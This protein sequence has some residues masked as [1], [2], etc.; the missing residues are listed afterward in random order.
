MDSLCSQAKGV[1]LQAAHLILCCYGALHLLGEV[2]N[3]L[4]IMLEYQPQP[5]TEL[6]VAGYNSVVTTALKA[7]TMWNMVMV[8]ILT[9]LSQESLGIGRQGHQQTSP[10]FFTMEAFF[11]SFLLNTASLQLSKAQGYIFFL[12]ILLFSMS[13]FLTCYVD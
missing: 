8:V 7:K 10:L 13:H 1:L 2:A 5:L 11:F 4:L 12:K 6:M 3:P 9:R